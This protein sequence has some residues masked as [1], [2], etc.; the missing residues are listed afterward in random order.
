[1]VFKYYSVQI[2]WCQTGHDLTYHRAPQNSGTIGTEPLEL[3][4][5]T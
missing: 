4:D 5:H 1:M 3:A 2:L